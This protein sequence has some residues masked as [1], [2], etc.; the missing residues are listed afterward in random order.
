MK[1]RVLAFL[2]SALLLTGSVP[3]FA[4]TSKLQD[5]VHTYTAEVG[6]TQFA[7]D[8]IMQPL[9]V[10]IYIKDGY[11]MLPLRTFLSSVSEY[12]YMEWSPETKNASVLIGEY[13]LTFDVKQ[14]TINNNSKSLPVF[15]QLEVK[16]GRLFVPLRNWG[17]ILNSCGYQVAP[18]DITWNSEAKQATIQVTE[19][20]VVPND[21]L[22]K[23]I[24]TGEGKAPVYAM[25][26][27]QKYNEINPIGNGLFLA[28]KYADRYKDL[29]SMDA[30]L[31]NTYAL[32]AADG[33][34]VFL[35]DTTGKELFHFEQDALFLLEYLGEGYFYA[36]SA[37][38]KD[39]FIINQEGK[40]LFS[41]PYDNIGKCSDGLFR[42]SKRVDG[43]SKD[44]YINTKG[45]EVIPVQFDEAEDFSEGLAVVSIA[46]GKYGFIDKSGT[47]VIEPTYKF[48]HSFHEGLASVRNENGYGYINQKGEAVIPLQY[49]NAGNFVDGLSYVTESESNQVWLINQK[50]EKLK[51]IT[52]ADGAS[53]SKRD[54]DKNN[55]ILQKE[56][57]VNLPNGDHTHMVSLY[58]E[59]GEI[60]YETYKFK[61]NLAEGF[62][63]VMDERNKKY[64][65]VD[66]TGKRIISADFDYASVFQDGYAVV[67][68]KVPQSDGKQAIAWGIIQHP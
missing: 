29:G 43:I 41:V 54:R 8:G 20:T 27:T 40:R 18:S 50:G 52:T 48:C 1:K 28:Q 36:V 33:K 9:D 6:T 37:D 5:V 25:E 51:L 32:I 62:A 19:S 17:N 26:L 49:Q 68:C 67:A 21:E 65:Y 22:E 39:K 12:A 57:I 47:F 14:N 38:F 45:E 7:K 61:T 34:E 13:V 24:Y 4:A 59:T 3:T 53:V 46:P 58:D 56:E 42:V 15:G 60:S 55:N 30:S 63:P 31:E 2:M 10:D 23:P 35:I 44:G 66:E 11:V 16:D 64:G